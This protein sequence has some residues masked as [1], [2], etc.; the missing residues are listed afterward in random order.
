V[1]L[2]P[3]RGTVAAARC[4]SP[5]AG[6]DEVLVSQW[7][8][9]ASMQADFATHYGSKPDG[10]CGSYTGDPASGLRSTWGGQQPQACYV[11][12]SGAAVVLWE[13]V[14]SRLQLLA[15]RKDGDAKAAF[16]WWQEAVKTP[17]TS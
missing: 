3:S 17:L 6:V 1:P 12:S 2:A 9:A 14:A 8:D 16:A 13:H 11:N 5:R 15:I 7:P 4:T 10:K